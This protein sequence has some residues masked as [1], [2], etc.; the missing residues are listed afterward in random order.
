VLG[1]PS[2]ADFTQMLQDDYGWQPPATPGRFDVLPLLLQAKPDEA[3]QVCWLPVCLLGIVH[4]A[5]VTGLA[6]P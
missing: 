5:A 1:D 4:N 6:L 2:E 3:P